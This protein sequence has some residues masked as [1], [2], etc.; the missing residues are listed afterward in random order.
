MRAGAPPPG[1]GGPTLAVGAA[2]GAA[3]ALIL[4]ADAA[5]WDPAVVAFASN[6]PSL[7]WM[8]FEVMKS[9]AFGCLTVVVWRIAV[10]EGPPT[11]EAVSATAGFVV[12]SLGLLPLLVWPRPAWSLN[13]PLPHGDVRAILLGALTMPAVVLIAY[14][15]VRM[16][17]R[18]R[19][20]RPPEGDLRAQVAGYQ[21]LRRRLQRLLVAAGT[22]IGLQM[23]TLATLREAIVAGVPHSPL[24][25]VVVVVFAV[26]FSGLLTVLAIPAWSAVGDEG[27]RLADVLAPLP[28]DP[29]EMTTDWYARRRASLEF[30]GLGTGPGPVLQV[31]LAV[32]GPLIGA[33][34][35]AL[36]GIPG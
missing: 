25:R 34:L 24:S 21:H 20:A 31:V 35:G 28:V 2:F 22:L 12:L 16:G 23:L 26:Y 14:C 5:G 15:V 29:G 33:G 32:L 18:L 27:R 19:E 10:A 36:L 13:T 4:V 17:Q 1:P 6:G 30:L 3:A 8:A 9:A 7:L 11:R